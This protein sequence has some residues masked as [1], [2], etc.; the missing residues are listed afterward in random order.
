MC[1]LVLR[2]EF[3]VYRV[4]ADRRSDALCG[5]A[6]IACEHDGLA[7]TVLPQRADG[8]RSTCSDGVG[9]T[10]HARIRSIHGE[11]D[12]TRR[13]G[14]REVGDA[15]LAEVCVCADA[16]DTFLA[17]RSDAAPRVLLDVMDSRRSA[18]AFREGTHDGARH[19][20]GGVLLCGGGA[21]EHL[22]L[23]SACGGE[24][25]RY[26]EVALGERACLV[27]DDGVRAGERVEIGAALDEEPRTGCR[28]EPREEGERN[29]DDEGAGAGDDEEG[30]RAVDPRREDVSRDE[31][32]QD[33]D[34]ESGAY[35]DG[36]IDA[37]KA[38]DERL[39]PRL[40]IRRLLH[41]I[42]N[43]RRSGLR[44]GSC[45][46][47]GQRARDVDAAA[48]ERISRMH[49]ARQGLSRERS[50][51]E[52]ALACG[53]RSVERHALPRIDADHA[54]DGDRLGVYDFLVPVHEDARR[55]GADVHERRDGA[56]CALDGTILQELTEL[57]EQHDSGGLGVVAEREG[58]ERGGAHE[59]VLTKEMPLPQIHG[60]APEN[61]GTDEDIRREK[62]N[63][64]RRPL[65]AEHTEEKE[66]SCRRDARARGQVRA[67]LRR[68]VCASAPAI[69]RLCC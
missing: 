26:T 32:R 30:Q 42:Q 22:L 16:D 9:D 33:S 6:G 7:D 31:G 3:G 49:G 36:G 21:G 29:G 13:C 51:V 1:R 38:R 62:E 27:K 35:D 12:R 15:A 58:A 57:I 28:A 54:A 55:V 65:A 45:D 63:G 66:Q 2:Q 40:F 25:A 52:R 67:S 18:A 64:A 19:R 11:P 47:D 56:A 41:E 48:E 46:A 34:A 43:A 4:D 24:N 10:D 68:R 8:V 53:H 44:I 37:R 39:R 17:A 61:I 69:M 5:G 14:R 59:K 23:R 50:G 20:M 60:G